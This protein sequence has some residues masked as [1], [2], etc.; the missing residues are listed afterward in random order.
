MNGG[1]RAGQGAGLGGE[2]DTCRLIEETLQGR[3]LSSHS[4]KSTI[5]SGQNHKATSLPWFGE[6]PLSAEAELTCIRRWRA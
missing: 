5:A 3:V 6:L 4:V 2:A 1:E